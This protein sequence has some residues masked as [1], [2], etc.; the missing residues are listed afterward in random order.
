MNIGRLNKRITIQQQ[1][2]GKDAG[3][4]PSGS[5]IDV[6]TVWAREMKVT[7]KVTTDDLART[8]ERNRTWQVRYRSGL[9]TDMRVKVAADYYQVTDIRII[10]RNSHLEIDGYH[11]SNWP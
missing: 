4:E 3:G 2:M 5:W 6:A 11:K 8:V 1:T 7:G 10:D 9:A